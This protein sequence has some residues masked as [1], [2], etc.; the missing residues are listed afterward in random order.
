M[1]DKEQLA[2]TNVTSSPHA[3]AAITI[4]VTREDNDREYR[5][6]YD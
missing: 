3:A 5:Y 6:Y 2:S 4:K 1:G